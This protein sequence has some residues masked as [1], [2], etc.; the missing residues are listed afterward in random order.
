VKGRIG[1]QLATIV[2]G[3]LVFVD[4]GFNCLAVG[5]VMRPVARANRVS[6]AK[7]AYL[8]DSTAAPVCIIAPVSSWAAAVAGFAKGAGAENGL[9][10]FVAAI[11]YNFYAILTIVMLF[12]L[13]LMKFDYGPMRR[14]ELDAEAGRP[15]LG[16]LVRAAEAHTEGRGGVCDLLVPFII[17]VAACVCGMAHSGGFFRPGETFHDFAAALANADGPVGLALGAAVG[18]LFSVIWCLA[19]RVVAFRDCMEILPEGFRSMVP[20]LIILCCAW[21]L[22]G[23]TESL[24]AREFISGLVNGPAAGLRH[25]LPAVFFVV[26]VLLSFATGTSWGTF[27]ILIP[28]VLA[29]LPQG[30]SMIMGISACL[31]GAV[32][33]DHCSPISD[34][35]IMS[36]VGTQ[37]DHIVHVSTQLPYALTVA[38]VSFVS[39]LT[40]P[41][42]GS[43][44]IAL[45]ASI[46]MLLATLFG[47]RL[48]SVRRQRS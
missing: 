5:S 25:F 32:C 8:V 9:A 27:G 45:T 38:A 24:G 16:A 22:N 47:L 35:T 44:W 10:L 30:Q 43:V 26:A 28:I 40:A 41:F 1:A 2:M 46:V 14:H 29:A 33:G 7:L 4:D 19:R 37:C 39:Y 42:V 3:L 23:M 21:A 34:T 12:A 11:P 20:G 6:T 31:A 18:V 17:L 15:D 36:S 13:T 48:V